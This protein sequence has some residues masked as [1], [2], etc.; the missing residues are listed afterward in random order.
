MLK[1]FQR[2]QQQ[3]SSFNSES[4]YSKRLTRK[5]RLLNMKSFKLSVLG[6]QSVETFQQLAEI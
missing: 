4:Y 1:D 6:L 5:N 3:K 2:Q